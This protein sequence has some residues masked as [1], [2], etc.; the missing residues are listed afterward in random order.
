MLPQS[1]FKVSSKTILLPS[2]TS[3]S[4]TYTLRTLM[5][6]YCSKGWIKLLII[7]SSLKCQTIDAYGM[8][9]CSH[10]STQS[11]HKGEVMYQ[12]ARGILMIMGRW[13]LRQIFY[14]GKWL[15]EK[16]QLHKLLEGSQKIRVRTKS[17]WLIICYCNYIHSF[18]CP[19]SCEIL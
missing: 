17:I 9:I 12:R 13:S 6:D 4:K 14:L 8:R 7:D 19:Q 1:T 18:Y 15:A 10:F 11:V 3:G 5:R 16:R 2:I